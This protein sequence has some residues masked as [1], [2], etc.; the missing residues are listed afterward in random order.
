MLFLKP[1]MKDKTRYTSVTTEKEDH[2]FTPA[3]E[4]DVDAVERF[5]ESEAEIPPSLVTPLKK[6]CGIR[7]K[8]KTSETAETASSVLMKYILD[9]E[10]NR[11]KKKS[12]KTI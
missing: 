4:T 3:E 7:S 10:K 9:E 6:S 11:R 1:Y 8:Q 5:Q 12:V 2:V